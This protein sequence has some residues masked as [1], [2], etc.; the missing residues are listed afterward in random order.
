METHDLCVSQGE[1]DE[2]ITSALLD[3]SDSSRLRQ[4]LKNP[5]SVNRH[6]VDIVSFPI[7]R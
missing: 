7:E 3:R 4:G 5:Q 6:R 1:M 2:K